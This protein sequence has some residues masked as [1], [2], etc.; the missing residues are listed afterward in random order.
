ME[1]TWASRDLPVLDAV[2]RLLEDKHEVRLNDLVTAAGLEAGMIVRAL[3]ALEGPY[4]AKLVKPWG[5]S[6]DRPGNW[7][8]HGITPA[9]RQAVGQWPT[10]E[11]LV[12]QLAAAFAA[13]ADAEPD[14]GRRGRLRQVAGFLGTTGRDVATEVV[15]KVIMRSLGVG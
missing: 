11:S 13:A 4:I 14:P 7:L 10:P 3:N 6:P 8:V 2:V 9:A 5:A 1:D 12:D 15:S